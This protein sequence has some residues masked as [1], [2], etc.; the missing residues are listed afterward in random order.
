MYIFQTHIF[1]Q[2][3]EHTSLVSEEGDVGGIQL[4]GLVVVLKSCGKVLLLVGCIA[5]LFLSHCLLKERK[6]GCLLQYIV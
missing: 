1:T 4:N 6:I 2:T 5:F 3:H